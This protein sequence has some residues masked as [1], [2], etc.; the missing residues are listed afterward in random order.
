METAMT[1]ATTGNARISEV[2]EKVRIDKTF[3]KGCFV[4]GHDFSRAENTQTTK[5]FSP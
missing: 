5:G 3:F 4:S 2:T 1:S